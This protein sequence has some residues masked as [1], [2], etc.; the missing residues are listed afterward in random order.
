MIVVVILKQLLRHEEYFGNSNGKNSSG[1]FFSFDLQSDE[2]KKQVP[3][4]DRNR[5]SWLNNSLEPKSKIFSLIEP[6]FNSIR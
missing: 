6:L 5:L 2:K 4:I 1:R 3:F